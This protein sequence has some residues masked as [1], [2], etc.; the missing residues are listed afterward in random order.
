MGG[1]LIDPLGGALIDPRVRA[2]RAVFET[3]TGL[4]TKMGEC[5]VQANETIRSIHYMLPCTRLFG[6]EDYLESH[7][8][9]APVRKRNLAPGVLS[10]GYRRLNS[11]PP[12]KWHLAVSKLRILKICDLFFKKALDGG[13]FSTQNGPNGTQ[14]CHELGGLLPNVK[15]SCVCGGWSGSKRRPAGPKLKIAH[16]AKTRQPLFSESNVA[17]FV[18][19]LSD[20][21]EWVHVGVGTRKRFR[22][23]PTHRVAKLPRYMYM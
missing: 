2:S 20:S 17:N 8:P 5:R 19:G 11:P 16:L 18:P 21:W 22:N 14:K 15:L 23:R 13:R 3:R 12:A 4:L 1:A 6:Q 9:S 10:E 7:P